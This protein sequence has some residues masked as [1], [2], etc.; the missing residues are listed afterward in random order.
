MKLTAP[1]AESGVIDIRNMEWEQFAIATNGQFK[2]EVIYRSV[3]G[4]HSLT[5]GRYWPIKNDLGRN[6]YVP[7]MDVRLLKTGD[8]LTIE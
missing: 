4:W 6:S 1:S 2:G 7:D 5:N 8:T 3:A